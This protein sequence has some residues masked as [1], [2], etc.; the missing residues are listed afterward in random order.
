[1]KIISF[2]LSIVF[3]N[4]LLSAKTINLELNSKTL[5]GQVDSKYLSFAID[6]AYLLGINF[7]KD[8]SESDEEASQKFHK[9]D[10]T[11][12][13]LI[14]LT[15]NLGPSYLR[16]GGSDADEIYYNVFKSNDKKYLN[17][18][19]LISK[20]FKSSLEIKDW[21]NLQYFVKEINGS[22]MFT[23]NAGP[24]SRDESKNWNNQNF[25][26]LLNFTKKRNDPKIIWEFGNEVNAWWLRY[27]LLEQP[28]PLAYANDYHLA[29]STLNKYKNDES[30]AGPASAFWPLAGENIPVLSDYTSIVAPEIIPLIFS[31][32]LEQSKLYDFPVDL[33][34]WHYYPTQSDRCPQLVAATEQNFYDL[35]TYDE[36][37]KWANKV[38]TDR[39]NNRPKAN[40]WLGESG[41]AQC[42]GQ[43]GLSNTYLNSLW[44]MDHLGSVALFDSKVVIRQ[45]LVGSDYGLLNEA[46]LKPTA[47][48]FSSILWKQLMGEKVLKVEGLDL[49]N[50]GEAR[51]YAHCTPKSSPYYEKSSVSF[52]LIN[53]SI[54]KDFDFILPEKILNSNLTSASWN[55][56]ML[57]TDGTNVLSQTIKLN[58]KILVVDE[59]G[60]LPSMIPLKN[61]YLLKK[62]ITIKPFNMAFLSFKVDPEKF[63]LCEN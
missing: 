63:N 5:A 4:Q 45:S 17:H 41:P 59:S 58:N 62:S 35:S 26:E 28:T 32:F 30:L 31:G 36:V 1:M 7:W 43:K 33:V 48:Y 23:I 34:T 50:P 19:Q 10:L 55:E 11:N 53:L 21:E 29:H 46:D 25:I 2:V 27:G 42:G 6:S 44:W 3:I 51:I 16:I 61:T 8:D 37:R 47:D 22:L 18:D 57:T 13:K 40:L 15:K 38:K 12:K 52:L 49:H 24:S 20:N 60:N 39:D 54:N 9:L 14:K 56:W